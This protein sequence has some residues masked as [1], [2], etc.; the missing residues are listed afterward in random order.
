MPFGYG[1][2]SAQLCFSAFSSAHI[3]SAHLSSACSVVS[4]AQLISAH[5]HSACL[6]LAQLSPTKL[7]SSQLCSSQLCSSQLCS[8]QLCSSQ[9]CL[10]QLC[11]AQH[12]INLLNSVQLQKISSAQVNSALLCH[13]PDSSGPCRLSMKKNLTSPREMT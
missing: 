1:L 4:S 9:L 6:E 3:V 13:A 11:S 7:S 10:P 2:S 5:L 12:T 8:S